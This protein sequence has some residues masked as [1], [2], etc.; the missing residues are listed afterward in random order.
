MAVHSLSAVHARQVFVVVLHT[1]V[2]PEQVVLSVHC[3]HAPAAEHAGRAVL[4]AA[5]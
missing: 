4:F 5:H 2:V 1:G 3:T